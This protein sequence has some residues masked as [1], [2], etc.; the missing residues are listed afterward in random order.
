[1]DDLQD[2]IALNLI[3]GVGPIRIKK[4]IDNLGN[5][6]RVFDIGPDRLKKI[7]GFDEVLT[8]A[9]YSADFRS[10]AVKEMARAEE[11]G[12][13][14]IT[15]QDPAYPKYLKKI[16]DPPSVLYLRG[17]LIPE[18]NRAIAVV[19][20]RRWTD[21]GRR[22]TELLSGQLAERGIR[23][24]SGL[25]RGID[26][27]AHRA[28]VASGGRTLAVLG[29]GLD[30]VYPSENR[31]LAESIA[32]QGV[33]MSE[34]PLGTRP[35]AGNFPR[36]NR[37]ISGLSLGVVVVEAGER[38]GALITASFAL[39]QG[40]DVFA[41]PGSATAGTSRGA[42]RLIQEGAKLVVEVEDILEELPSV[43]GWFE[44][45][46]KARIR[47]RVELPAEEAEVA[48]LLGE[49]PVH[50]DALARKAGKPTPDLLS[51][52]TALEL[53]GVIRQLS[54]KMFVRS[55]D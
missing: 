4:L 54:G 38:S 36:R 39:E 2:W 46:A 33:I 51:T 26:T 45:S 21:Y 24:V 14:I 31:K 52:L 13:R 29:N 28:A 41:V 25:A 7:P 49:T 53:K 23:V 34:F 6:A 5:P 11:L 37:I 35:L 32:G 50:V 42:N 10:L 17:E 20:S 9:V 47:P 12:L 44:P 40:R 19:G 30:V 43:V 3:P 55:D 22:I 8:R 18:D 16:Y 48:G 1:M 27:F 15:L